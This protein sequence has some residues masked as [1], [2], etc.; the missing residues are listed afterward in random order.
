MSASKLLSIVPMLLLAAVVGAAVPKPLDPIL[1]APHM[2]ELVFKNEKVRVLRQTVRNGE[3]S[4]LHGHLDRV[5]VYLQSCAWLEDDGDGGEQMK[6]FKI[7]DAVWAPAE[8]HGGTTA[9][10]VQECKILEIELL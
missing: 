4:P 7:G 5:M 3:T 1:V 9:N 6:L 8:A 2:Y 10:V